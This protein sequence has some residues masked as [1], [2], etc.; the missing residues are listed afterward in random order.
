MLVEADYSAVARD[1]A[2]RSI[3]IKNMMDDI[4]DQAM[5]EAVPIPN[6]SSSAPLTMHNT[7]PFSIGQR[8][9]PQQSH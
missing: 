5:T 2:E 9:G 8:G 3:L 4:G 6:V 7:D 1:V